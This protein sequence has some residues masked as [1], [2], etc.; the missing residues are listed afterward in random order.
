MDA[1]EELMSMTFTWHKFTVWRPMR[2]SS[3]DASE[4]TYPRFD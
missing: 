3:L 2:H 4:M 1:E